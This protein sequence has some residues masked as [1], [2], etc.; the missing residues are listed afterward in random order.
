MNNYNLTKKIVVAPQIIIYKNIFKDSEKIIRSVEEFSK[1][2]TLWPDWEDWYSQGK[3]IMAKFNRKDLELNKNDSE[4]IKIE[5][6][7]LK[8]LYSVFDFVKNDYLKQYGEGLGNWPDYIKNWKKVES[9]NKDA[10]TLDIYKYDVVYNNESEMPDDIMMDF[11]VDEMPS[12]AHEDIGFYKIITITGYLNNNYVGGEICFY[13]EPSNKA[14]K[15]KPNPGDITVFPSAA[16]FYHGVNYF[17]GADRY[18][19]RAFISYANDD[20][21]ITNDKDS[22]GSFL[23]DQEDKTDKFVKQYSH[24]ITLEFPN[25]KV[26]NARARIVKLDEEINIVKD[27]ND[28]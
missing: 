26:H 19:I 7:Y 17:S 21:L 20:S 2:D 12:G 25:K 5:K 18:F 9:S 8:E 4:N 1:D 24:A 6:K 28:N 3:H 15:Y 10:I 23:K 22:I 14:Y 16:P 11:H 13:D 27:K